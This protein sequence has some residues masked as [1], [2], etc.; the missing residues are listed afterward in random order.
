M[1]A[2]SERLDSVAAAPPSLNDKG[3]GCIITFWRIVS[4][5]CSLIN[6]AN[7]GNL[8]KSPKISSRPQLSGAGTL[9][10]LALDDSEGGASTSPPGLAHTRHTRALEMSWV[11]SGCWFSNNLTI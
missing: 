1:I 8:E 11:L 9:V 5:L 6:G 3:F 7:Y 2:A 10:S 4:P